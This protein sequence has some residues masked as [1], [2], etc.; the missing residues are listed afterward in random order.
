MWC[1]AKASFCAVEAEAISDSLHRCVIVCGVVQR[2]ETDL[3]VKL[4]KAKD[5]GDLFSKG[6]ASMSTIELR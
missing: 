5:L 1:T 3:I 6:L 4:P 2:K